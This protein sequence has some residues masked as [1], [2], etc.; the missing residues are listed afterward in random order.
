[1]ATHSFRIK[2]KKKKRQPRHNI[3]S[4]SVGVGFRG[5]TQ[6]ANIST[7]VF[8]R[9]SSRPFD[10]SAIIFRPFFRRFPPDRIRFWR[11]GRRKSRGDEGNCYFPWSR[12]TRRG[13]WRFL[14]N[15]SRNKVGGKSLP[16]RYWTPRGNPSRSDSPNK[17]LTGKSD[18]ETKGSGKKKPGKKNPIINSEK[19]PKHHTRRRIIIVKSAF[20]ACAYNEIK[21]ISSKTRVKSTMISTVIEAEQV[22]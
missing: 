9:R 11:G 17:R 5:K 10:F 8:V 22:V 19:Y 3:A 1:M 4:H 6:N 18:P 13:R 20:S 2:K 21:R 15:A 16:C 7:F 12:F 14:E